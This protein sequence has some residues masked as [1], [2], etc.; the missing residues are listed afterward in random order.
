MDKVNE[1]EHGIESRLSERMDNLIFSEKS[2][3]HFMHHDMD[4][5]V[6]TAKGNKGL[7]D[8]IDLF[9]RHQ[10]ER[11]EILD[12]YSKGQNYSVLH[13]Q[14][15]L[16]KNKAD[17]RA[18]HNWGGYISSFITGYV[19]GN[20]IGVE[21]RNDSE[22]NIECIQEIIEINDL[23]TTDYELAY[24]TS[25]YGRAFELHY[26]NEEGQ[27][28]IRLIDADEMFVIRDVTVDKEIVGVV[29]LPIINDDLYITIYTDKEI[30]SYQPTESHTISLTGVKRQRHFY[31]DVPV[32]EWMNNRFR[33]G[34]F[35]HQIPII[36]L[37]D[38][39]QSDTANYMSDLND[40]MLVI[41]GD[42][43]SADMSTEDVVKMK[44][45]NML[46]LESGIDP[47]GKQQ[48]M[49][50]DYI[51]KKYDVAGTEAY[52]T[53]LMNDIYKLSNVPNLDDDRFYSGQSGI[54]LQY[55][56]IGLEQIRATKE[57]F[58]KRA[59]KRRYRLISN[60]HRNLNDTP[61]N[62]DD[63]EFVFHPNIPQD[64][65]EEVQQYLSAGGEL[66][67][68]TLS[69]LTTF[70]NDYEDEKVKLEKESAPYADDALL[71]FNQERSV[72]DGTD[73]T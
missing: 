48:S 35:E 66:S 71:F 9:L 61:I 55:K 33:N 36:D 26:R 54:A 16:E 67:Q 42:F 8:M 31:D 23:K 7:I 14:R 39:A 3:I 38:S 1:F 69:G 15:R 6:N 45:A 28:C 73:E 65:W 46:L 18:R 62:A 50:A 72:G 64:V 68:E 27:D 29:H 37:Y 10:K 5:L 51:Y 30:I 70:I 53:R 44:D 43:K 63:L 17:Y 2:N 13:G 58:Y 12:A 25:R 57:A 11:I 34:D 56:M 21:V 49:S 47:S 59:L 20:D 22:T 60:V 19:A 32:V 4:E 40:A 41:N 52:K 24:D